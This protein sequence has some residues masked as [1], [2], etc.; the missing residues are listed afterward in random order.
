[1]NCVFCKIVAG[2]IP[3]TKVLETTDVVAIRDISPQ[4]PVHVLV[5]PRR[6]VASLAELDDPGLAEALLRGVRD[7]AAREG[8]KDFRTIANTGAGA[9]QSVFH[10]H[11]HVMGGRAMGA[12]G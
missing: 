9:G 8:L 12:L 5:M 3:S 10:L 7:V 1:M 11:F 2:E 6:H 4:A